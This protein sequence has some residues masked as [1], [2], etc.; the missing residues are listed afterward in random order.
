MRIR[1]L[2]VVVR[3]KCVM[4]RENNVRRHGLLYALPF[5]GFARGVSI[6]GLKMAAPEMTP[7]HWPFLG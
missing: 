4:L 7:R 5:G 1:V 6:C 3:N 2:N